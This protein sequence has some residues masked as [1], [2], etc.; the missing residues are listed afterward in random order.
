MQGD[1]QKMEEV[2]QRVGVS[3]AE[4][5]YALEE[6]GGDVAEAVAIAERDR[7]TAGAGLAAAGMSFLDELKKAV[8]G[9]PIRALRLKFGNRTVK[10]LSVA[11]Q[12]ALAVLGIAALAVLVTKLHIEVE[13]APEE[14]A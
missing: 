3:Y 7:E 10:E 11:P 8:S 9:G 4:A 14:G 13:R 2:R 1:L 5:R 12:T 6:A